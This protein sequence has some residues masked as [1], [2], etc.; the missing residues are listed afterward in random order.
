MT[1]K[2]RNGVPPHTFAAIR[3]ALHADREPQPSRPAL[4]HGAPHI[5]TN[6]AWNWGEDKPD[7]EDG[8]YEPDW[9]CLTHDQSGHGTGCPD[10]ATTDPTS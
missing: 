10:C 4:G 5:G 8:P 6:H 7:T 3:D 1:R 2:Q 9:W